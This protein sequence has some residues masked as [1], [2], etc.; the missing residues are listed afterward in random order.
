[1]IRQ[2]FVNNV[3]SLHHEH[4]SY[5]WWVLANI[6]ISTFMVVLDSHHRQHGAS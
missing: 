6:M 1:M 2:R 3:P 5:K 4:D